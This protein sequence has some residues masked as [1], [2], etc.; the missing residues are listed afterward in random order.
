M[1][2]LMEVCLNQLLW[3]DGGKRINSSWE[4]CEKKS[5]KEPLLL[6]AYRIFTGNSVL[7]DHP[8]SA[9]KNIEQIISLK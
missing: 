5:S 8:E 7:F 2:V 6:P 3:E 4:T 9:E 1:D